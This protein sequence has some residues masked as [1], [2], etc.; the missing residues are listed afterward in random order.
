MVVV[1]ATL[2][3][4]TEF[5]SYTVLKP[6]DHNIA[7]L[8][9]LRYQ[10]VT[11]SAALPPLRGAFRAQS[12]QVDHHP[13]ATSTRGGARCQPLTQPATRRLTDV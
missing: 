13:I 1:S 2:S 7:E 9:K 6:G 12:E 5:E 4:L 10:I 11:W 3:L 8:G